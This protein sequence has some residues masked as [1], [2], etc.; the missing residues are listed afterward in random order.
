MG[1]QR[2][3]YFSQSLLALVISKLIKRINTWAAARSI[4]QLCVGVRKS[5][6]LFPS[7]HVLEFLINIALF[8]LPKS[9][10]VGRGGQWTLFR[11]VD[12]LVTWIYFRKIFFMKRLVG[13]L[14]KLS[15]QILVLFIIIPALVRQI[16]YWHLIHT[17]IIASWAYFS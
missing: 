6:A 17:A 8:K 7:F 16:P 3:G 10:G 12:Q 1:I 15:L 5:H 2:N 14:L 4:R 11:W 13:L 9:I